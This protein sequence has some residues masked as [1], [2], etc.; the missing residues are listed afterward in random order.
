[1]FGRTLRNVL[2][3]MGYRYGRG[4]II[5]QMNDAWYVGR[6]RTFLIQ[7]SRAVV[8][9]LQGRCVIVYMDES[10]V[11]TNH[12]RQ[13]TCYH[14]EAPER[15]TCPAQRCRQAAGAGACFH[16]RRLADARSCCS[17]RPLRSDGCVVRAGVR[18]GEGRWGLPRQHQWHDLHALADQSTA[19]R[20]LSTVSSAGHGAGAGPCLLS[21]SPRATLDQCTPH[22]QSSAGSQAG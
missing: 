20:L 22:E 3:S 6:I 9:Q 15:E 10:Y 17:Q 19:A 7:Y 13:F 8:E 5:G 1:M 4:N 2:S 21:P 14:P 16:A 12:A 11:N 18:G